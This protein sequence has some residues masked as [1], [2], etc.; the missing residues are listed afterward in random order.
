MER[1]QAEIST[2][3]E[4]LTTSSRNVEERG[5]A[6]LRAR[7]PLADHD[8]RVARDRHLGLQDRLLAAQAALGSLIL[9][10]EESTSDL[11]AG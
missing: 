7:T 6:M 9:E 1:L 11:G 5:Q 10:R 3:R 4:Q 2:L 8:F